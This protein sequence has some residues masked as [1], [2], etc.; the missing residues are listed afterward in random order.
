MSLFLLC[1]ALLLALCLFFLLRGLLFNTAANPYQKR[2]RALERAL[3]DGA[4][5]KDEFEQK[6][7]ALKLELQSNT[8]LIPNRPA[9]R[10]AIALS[11]F[12]LLGSSFIYYSF[13][14]PQA[15]DAK[16]LEAK[17]APHS[18]DPN[19]KD[20]MPKDMQTATQELAEKLKKSP[21]D[22]D[23]WVLLTRSYKAMENFEQALIAARTARQLAPDNDDIAIEYAETA[24]MAKADRSLLGEPT[25]I[26]DEVLQRNPNHER[27]LWMR[28]IA[29]AQSGDAAN[30]ISRWRQL[31]AVMPSDAEVRGSIEEQ[32]RAI[33]E[34][35][36]IEIGPMPSAS[37]ASKT[38]ATE[39]NT[40]VSA[41]NS[42]Q[43]NKAD[44]KQIQVAI[45]ISPTLAAQRQAG[46]V[47]Y[48]F[49]RLPEGPRMPLAIQRVVD[50]NF[51]LQIL[52]DETMGMTP[53]MSIA[54]AE[55][56][57]VGARLSKSGIANAQ[58]GDFESDLVTVELNSGNANAELVINSIK[59]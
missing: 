49:A 39:N 18:A 35:A 11:A 30:A 8:G 19:N 1:A 26:V 36:G 10:L 2:E 22:I 25:Q 23:G 13:G 20:A 42:D 7:A 57:V 4:I 15:L 56:V 17:N 53:E 59:P 34:Q 14:A 58:S 48:V 6:V 5:A 40:T 37:G 31:L 38:V 54:N 52:L 50:A 32:I 45:S 3:R 41:K 24:A 29:Y 55:K 43:T 47:L 51:P 27:G 28:G 44:K 21:N 16:N 46:D 9:R 33:A 12:F